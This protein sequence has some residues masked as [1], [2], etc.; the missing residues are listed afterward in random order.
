MSLS[1]PRRFR[2]RLLILLVCTCGLF[3]GCNWYKQLKGDNFD[4][5]YATWGEDQRPKEKGSGNELFGLSSKAQ[6]V[7]RNLGYH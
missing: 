3:S 2:F 7:E 6:Q 4:D 1:S 5:E